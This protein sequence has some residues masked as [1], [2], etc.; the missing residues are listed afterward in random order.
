M[1]RKGRREGIGTARGLCRAGQEGAPWKGQGMATALAWVLSWMG[2]EVVWRVSAGGRSH[3]GAAQRRVQE[4]IWWKLGVA[5]AAA[6]SLLFV[7]LRLLVL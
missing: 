5:R 6:L 7:L 3:D 1:G 4:R 2:K